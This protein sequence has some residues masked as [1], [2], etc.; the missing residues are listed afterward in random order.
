M[1]CQKCQAEL[2]KQ[3]RFCNQCGTPAPPQSTVQTEQDINTLKGTSIGV[4]DNQTERRDGLSISSRSEIGTIEDGGTAIGAILGGEGGNVHVGGQQ[5][6]NRR[7]VNT[8]GGSYI[9]GDVNAS[10]DFVGHDKIVHGDEVRGDKIGGDKTMMGNVSNSTV[11]AGSGAQ[12]TSNQGVSGAE[13]AAL[14][15]AIYKRI[16]ARP[17]NPDVDKEELQGTVQRIQAEAS[18][19]EEANPGKVRR[20]LNALADIAPDIL[21]VTVSSLINPIAGVATAIRS[22]AERV[23]QGTGTK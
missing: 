19:G 10:G 6:Y 14:F 12:A 8:G 4:I 13:L 23:L 1:I 7:E 21:E 16:D 18:K 5:N 9:G 2:P 11:A 20:W 3:A 17:D 15:D 22:V